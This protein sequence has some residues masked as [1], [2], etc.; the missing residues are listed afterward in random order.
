M[1]DRVMAFMASLFRLDEGAWERHANPWSVWT[2][3]ATWPA[4]MLVLWSFHWFGMWSLL[5]LAVTVGWLA[6]NPHA[7][8][9]PVSTR[10]WASRAVLGERVYLRRELHPVPIGHVN[11]AT[12]LS[13]GSGLGFLF[14]VAGLLAREPAERIRRRLTDGGIGESAADRVLAI[15]NFNEAP[16]DYRTPL[17][18]HSEKLDGHGFEPASV[19]DG[20]VRLPG[21]TAWFARLQ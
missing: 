4:L 5:P 21:Y 15:F 16:V 3:V 13:I 11:A 6:L 17:L 19:D 14:L 18:L 8:P 7:F 20:S 2:R 12:A 10:S 1:L 9:P